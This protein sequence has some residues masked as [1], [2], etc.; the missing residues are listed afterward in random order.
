MYVFLEGVCWDFEDVVDWE[1]SC[2]D[3][4]DVGDLCFFGMW[5]DYVVG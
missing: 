3:V 5:C 4:G 2:V 1:G